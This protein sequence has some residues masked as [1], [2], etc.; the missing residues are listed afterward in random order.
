MTGT[1][2]HLIPRCATILPEGA[3]QSV[4]RYPRW[5]Y[6]QGRTYDRPIFVSV[7][8]IYRQRFGPTGARRQFLRPKLDGLG[9]DLPKAQFQIDPQIR[10]PVF[11]PGP[12][13]NRIR[14]AGKLRSEGLQKRLVCGFSGP[15]TDL[16]PDF[17]PDFFPIDGNVGWRG[18]AQPSAATLNPEYGNR[19]FALW[20]HN[21]LTEL[22]TE[23][24]HR[25]FS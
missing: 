14:D 25:F 15:A 12:Q 4:L 24:E 22:A 2:C 13:G 23:D 8:D 10:G 19:Q 6:G 11:G 5:T 18:D 20:Y 1:H 9:K 7:E 16:L 17:V 21:L 3:A